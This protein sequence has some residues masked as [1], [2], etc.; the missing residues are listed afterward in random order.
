MVARSCDPHFNLPQ[1][2][3]FIVVSI[4][5]INL[6]LQVVDWIMSKKIGKDSLFIVNDDGL[7]PLT[8]AARRG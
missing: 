8:L 6:S 2:I 7:T 5:H 1:I 3:V 4:L